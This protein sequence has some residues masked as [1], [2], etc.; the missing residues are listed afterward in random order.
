MNT[1]QQKQW[2]STEFP[3]NPPYQVTQLRVQVLPAN[4]CL[5]L[6]ASLVEAAA[7]WL[8]DYGI[9]GCKCMGFLL[10]DFRPQRNGGFL[11]WWYPKTIGF[12]TKNDHFGVFW[13]YPYFWKHPNS[14]VFGLVRSLTHAWGLFWWCC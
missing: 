9:K 6:L 13:G 8:S 3:G 7:L 11:K 5:V 1:N 2:P 4:P 10:S 14:A 12:P